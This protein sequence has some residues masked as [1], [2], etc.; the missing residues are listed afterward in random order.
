MRVEIVN[1][2]KTAILQFLNSVDPGV[3]SRI[4]TFLKGLIK[5]IDNKWRECPNGKG[6]HRNVKEAFLK[7]IEIFVHYTMQNFLGGGAPK[8]ALP[9]H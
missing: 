3:G 4:L 2:Y 9:H 1:F 5:L 6:T 7:A 8:S